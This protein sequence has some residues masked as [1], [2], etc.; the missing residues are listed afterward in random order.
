MNGPTILVVDDDAD[1][2][3]Y[4]RGCLRGLVEGA[5]EGERGG[6][7][8]VLEAASAEEALQTMKRS[9]VDLV[10][11]DVVLPSLDGRALLNA[12]RSDPEWKRVPV[13]L[14]SGQE[15]PGSPDGAL[16]GWLSKPFNARQLLAAVE[17]LL[18]QRAGSS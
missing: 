4:V 3:L 6:A 7:G 1:M 5:P 17:Q 10:V 9:S 16:D 2:R 14:I 12:I 8:K 11:S 18:E 13:L 15:P